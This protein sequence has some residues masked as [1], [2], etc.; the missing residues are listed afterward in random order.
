M[1]SLR[2]L[3]IATRASKLALAQ[4]KSAQEL[5][6]Q[7]YPQLEVRLVEVVSEGDQTEGSLACQGGKELFVHALRE[8][9]VRGEADCACHSLKDVGPAD[10]SF[11]F[12]AFLRRADARDA[13]LGLSLAELAHRKT[14]TIATSSP[15]RSG[16]ISLL[17]PQAEIVPMRGNVDTR[18]GKLS[19]GEA[20]ALLLACAGL[21]RLGLDG[22][23]VERLELGQFIPAPGQ[24]T[25]AL[26]CLS[27]RAE[28]GR[29]LAV[30]N[31]N[32]SRIRSIAERSCSA[33][34]SG[35]CQTPLGA[36]AQITEDGNVDISCALTFG[37]EQATGHARDPDPEA[38]GTKAAERMLAGEG[39]LI[40]SKTR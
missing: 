12:A 32:P 5:L 24:G 10:P 19:D 33:K 9:L 4:A 13:L 6:G 18:I 17:L 29:L 14:V 28:V 26:E 8:A 11:V 20:D 3:R 22:H 37:G 31:D 21:D 16:L 15:R 38:A 1:P 36:H 27:T 23:I 25:I 30:L 34:V 35:D 2:C 40:L 39:N 7:H